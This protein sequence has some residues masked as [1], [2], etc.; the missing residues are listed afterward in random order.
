ME[1]SKPLLTVLE[2]CD[3]HSTVPLDSQSDVGDGHSTLYC[4]NELH[5]LLQS[6]Y[7]SALVLRDNNMV[8]C[9]VFNQRTKALTSVRVLNGASHLGY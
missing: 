5:L 8:A 4:V 2:R 1:S 3:C 6:P 7:V 9:E